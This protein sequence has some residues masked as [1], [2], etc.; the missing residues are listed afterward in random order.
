MSL[1]SNILAATVLVTREYS[2]AYTM[3]RYGTGSYSAT[4]GEWSEG[5]VTEVEV[6]ADLQP[7]PGHMIKLLPEGLVSEDMY[8]VFT[9][10]TLQK[11]SVGLKADEFVLI[12]GIYQVV[13]VKDWGG[14]TEAVISK[15][16]V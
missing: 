5:A 11:S 7:V 15:R 6:M 1:R 4:T 8:R 16:D 14:Y 13:Y 12:D 3:R 10:D 2:D 9:V